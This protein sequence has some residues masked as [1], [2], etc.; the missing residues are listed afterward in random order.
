MFVCAVVGL[1][2]YHGLITNFGT[3]ALALLINQNRVAAG[4]ETGVLSRFH[5]DQGAMR[6]GNLNVYKCGPSTI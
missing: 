1:R 3:P 5:P 2:S 4:L 6:S